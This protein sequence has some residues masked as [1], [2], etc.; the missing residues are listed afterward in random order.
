MAVLFKHP[1]PKMY[2]LYRAI[3]T[4][5][6]R[7]LCGVLS[8]PRPNMLRV[9][10][11]TRFNPLRP[12]GRRHDVW[13]KN[14]TLKLVIAIFGKWNMFIRY[15]FYK[16]SIY[17]PVWIERNLILFKNDLLLFFCTKL[18]PKTLNRVC[19]ALFK[20]HMG[21]VKCPFLSFECHMGMWTKYFDQQ[22]FDVGSF[23][24]TQENSANAIENT[25]LWW[26]IVQCRYLTGSRYY[27][28]LSSYLFIDK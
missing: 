22:R 19:N 6:G 14:V 20:C 13:K 24:V 9:P 1:D 7:P 3:D 16:D 15:W 17:V 26:N 21:S 28:L 25:V 8:L 10:H 4:K 23:V 11:L 2:A 18:L 5:V 12:R 27:Y